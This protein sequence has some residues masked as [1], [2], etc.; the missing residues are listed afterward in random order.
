MSPV[1][2]YEYYNTTTG[3][4]DGHERMTNAEANSLNDS[5]RMDKSDIRFVPCRCEEDGE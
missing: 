5:L 4:V 1:Y 2:V 3:E